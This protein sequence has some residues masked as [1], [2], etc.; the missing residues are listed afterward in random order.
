MPASLGY[1]PARPLP[2]GRGG[3]AELCAAMTRGTATTSTSDTRGC[4]RG[5]RTPVKRTISESTQC[6]MYQGPA[7]QGKAPV[8]L[9]RF[10]GHLCKNDAIRTGALRDGCR[11][12]RLIKS[13]TYTD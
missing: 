10:A 12:I 4:S 5:V 2:S 3:G 9:T 7:F 8:F 6:D 1:A 11:E 13:I